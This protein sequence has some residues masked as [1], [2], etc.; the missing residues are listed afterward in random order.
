MDKM[1][2]VLLLALPDAIRRRWA[3]QAQARFLL[4]PARPRPPTRPRRPIPTST[5]ERALRRC[6]TVRTR[7]LAAARYGNLHASVG[8]K[9]PRRLLVDWSNPSLPAQT[10]WRKLGREG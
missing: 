6:L 5:W 1:M 8:A 3:A 2:Q 10:V 9:L 4:L 7:R